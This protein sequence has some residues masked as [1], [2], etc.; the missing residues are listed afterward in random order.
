MINKKHPKTAEDF[1]KW[2]IEIS[3]NIITNSLKQGLTYNRFKTLSEEMQTGVYL[4]YFDKY[5]IYIEILPPYKE[6]VYKYTVWSTDLRDKYKSCK[7]R[8]LALK[9]A[10][11]KASEIREK[12]LKDNG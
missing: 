9:S 7:N 10:I 12:Q 4:R 6:T 5:R 11:Q 1:A 3:G 2:Y 8:T